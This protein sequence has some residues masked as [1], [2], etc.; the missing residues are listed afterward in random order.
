MGQFDRQ[1]A[2]EDVQKA[3]AGHVQST[4]EFKRI[5]LEKDAKE[6]EEAR[7]AKELLR[8][9]GMRSSQV[10]FAVGYNDPHYF[11]Y[12]FKKTVGMTPSEYRRE[13]E[14]QPE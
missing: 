7:K 13:N 9:G 4:A 8:L 1:K 3:V 10:A 14:N 11:S 6:K 12:L 2:E 5:A